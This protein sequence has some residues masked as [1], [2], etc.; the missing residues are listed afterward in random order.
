MFL[1]IVIYCCFQSKY[2]RTIFALFGGY[3]SF[4]FS[5]NPLYSPPRKIIFA[6][7]IY[8]TYLVSYVVANVKTSH[9]DCF[10]DVGL[11][12]R[13]FCRGPDRDTIITQVFWGREKDGN[14]SAFSADYRC[15]SGSRF[16]IRSSNVGIE[17]RPS[18]SFRDMS[19]SKRR[20]GKIYLFTFDN[21]FFYLFMF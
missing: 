20:A 2:K 13:T 6:A 11:S 9:A 18:G 17:W 14:I 4:I 3:R 19:K 16:G 12:C 1:F 7:F 5:K 8:S 10:A 21:S 15:E